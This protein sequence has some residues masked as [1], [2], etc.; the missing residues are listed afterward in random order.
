LFRYLSLSFAEII[1][2]IIAA[3]LPTC[4]NNLVEIT[5]HPRRLFDYRY[6]PTKFRED[7]ICRFEFTAN[8]GCRQN[9]VSGHLTPKW[10][11]TSGNS[12][13]L[14]LLD[15]ETNIC[16]AVLPVGEFTKKYINYMQVW[17][18]FANLLRILPW[19]DVHQILHSSGIAD[20][21]KSTNVL[22]IG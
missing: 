1:L 11:I 6:L 22:V 3:V 7:V 10:G 2:R 5:D 8:L 9:G 4:Y 15:L 13:S 17:L 16:T 12:K 21:I 20:L 19:T 14:S 18:Y